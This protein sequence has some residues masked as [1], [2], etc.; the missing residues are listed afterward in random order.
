MN[1]KYKNL[2]KQQIRQKQSRTYSAITQMLLGDG[3]RLKINTAGL[4]QIKQEHIN[5][6]TQN[7]NFHW[8]F[9]G[10]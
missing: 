8:K 3:Q 2:A 1:K 9:S 5:M 4:V 10:S 6:I 7:L